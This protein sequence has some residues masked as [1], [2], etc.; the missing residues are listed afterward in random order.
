MFFWIFCGSLCNNSKNLAL[1]RNVSPYPAINEL[2][3]WKG[4]WREGNRIKCFSRFETRKCLRFIQELERQ[5]LLAVIRDRLRSFEDAEYQGLLAKMC[6][7]KR[8]ET[9]KAHPTGKNGKSEVKDP[10]IDY[11]AGKHIRVAFSK[12]WLADEKD[13]ISYLSE[14]KKAMMKEI[15]SGKRIQI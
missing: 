11:V 5:T 14:L 4:Y 1:K 6:E 15:E 3:V 2:A 13:V 8:L 12:P 7:F 10:N 9:E